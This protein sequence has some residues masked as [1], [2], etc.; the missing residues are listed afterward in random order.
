V[1]APS[2][3]APRES[4]RLAVGESLLA[5]LLW[6]FYY[7]LI[8][9]ATAG[10]KPVA[11]LAYPF[12]F[13]GIA[14]AL[15]ATLRGEGRAFLGLWASPRAYV[16]TALLVA[17]Q[18]GVV[19]ATYLTGP[20][21]ASL[22]SLIGDVVATPL[23]AA[24]VIITYRRL[25]GRPAFLAGLGLSLVGGTL[26]IVGGERLR[27]VPPIAW[28]IVLLVP[29][30]VA[31][32]FLLVARTA[33]EVPT[34]AVVA[35]ATVSATL[36]TVIAAPWLPGGLAGLGS[37]GPVPA[38]L[39]AVTGVTSFFVGPALYFRAIGRVGLGIPP[40][41]MTGIP[42]FTLLLSALLLGLGAPLLGLL[43]IPIA[44]VGALLALRSEGPGR[45]APTESR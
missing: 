8:L 41:L 45:P 43:G 19:A 26:A 29:L 25:L 7:V 37:V 6:A 39:L 14:F 27:A 35:H 2:T 18:L 28:G 16:R 3:R 20:V 38:V 4:P 22:L 12:A 10:A 21:D 44:I 9:W 13:G 23:L 15:Y 33:E 24:L 36:V 34:A 30:T 31:A 1:R 5:A 17:M 11:I 42:V 32:Y 40:L